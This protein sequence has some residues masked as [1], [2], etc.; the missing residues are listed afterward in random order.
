[1]TRRHKLARYRPRLRAVRGHPDRPGTPA[2]GCLYTQVDWAP[3][4]H[5][6]VRIHQRDEKGGGYRDG[7]LRNFRESLKGEVPRISIPRTSVNTNVVATNCAEVFGAMS[8]DT[9]VGVIDFVVFERF[10]QNQRRGGN[11]SGRVPSRSVRSDVRQEP[12]H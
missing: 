7:V 1:M 6:C 9:N 12:P 2:T 4:P 5:T 11:R 8:E 10:S 3:S